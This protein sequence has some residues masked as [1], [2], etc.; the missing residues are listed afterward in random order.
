MTT[1]RTRKR[2][3]TRRLLP[4]FQ[5]VAAMIIVFLAAGWLLSTPV[6]ALAVPASAFGYD[7]AGITEIK[8]YEAA[9]KAQQY[10]GQAGYTASAYLNNS[11][12]AA[13][14]NFAQTA[15]W[16]WA[17]HGVSGE[18]RIKTSRIANG[19][20]ID[21]WLRAYPYQANTPNA[22]AD[23]QGATFY[24]NNLKRTDIT[25]LLLVVMQGCYTAQYRTGH[26]GDPKYN[27]AELLAA[28]KGVTTTLGF[29]GTISAATFNGVGNP[30]R[31]WATGFYAALDNNS[32]VRNAVD[33]ANTIYYA[34]FQDYGGYDTFFIYG[35]PSLC[36]EPARYGPVD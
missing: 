33:A 13:Y 23:T 24:L 27:L 10:L 32:T 28:E 5:R 31:V 25:Q 26:L 12:Y 16:H 2:R 1:M 18:A 22:N 21:Q 11:G 14:N 36:V 15:I 3:L 29:V 19:V 7:L 35:V 8:T 34:Y 4:A 20:R 30:T 9:Q 6:S 17:F